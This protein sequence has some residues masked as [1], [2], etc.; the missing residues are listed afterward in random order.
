MYAFDC[1]YDPVPVIFRT[2]IIGIEL[3]SHAKGGTV[4]LLC[5]FMFILAIYH[6]LSVMRQFTDQSGI[7]Y[8]SLVNS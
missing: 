1:G 5:V 2:S 7:S 4:L 3:T 6:L 8:Y